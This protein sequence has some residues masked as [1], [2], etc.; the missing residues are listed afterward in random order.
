TA[1]PDVLRYLYADNTV[2]CAIMK[3]RYFVYQCLLWVRNTTKNTVSERCLKKHATLCGDGV[4]LY[5]KDTCRD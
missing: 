4:P 3:L 2:T 1:N 5:D